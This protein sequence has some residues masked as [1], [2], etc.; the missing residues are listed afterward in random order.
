MGERFGAMPR[1]HAVVDVGARA[2]DDGR[3]HN[4]GKGGDCGGGKGH[5]R[6]SDDG[7]RRD[8]GKGKDGGEGR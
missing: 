5:V 4:L 3:C 1:S 8:L 2:D 7:R 6:A